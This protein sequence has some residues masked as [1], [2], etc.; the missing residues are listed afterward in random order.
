MNFS[1]YF[2]FLPDSFRL[3]YPSPKHH[4]PH[5]RR[6]DST[7]TILKCFTGL[8]LWLLASSVLAA[9]GYIQLV[10]GNAKV[11]ERSGTERPAQTG[12]QLYEGDSV[13]TSAGSTVRIRMND[14]ALLWV[15]PDSRLKI[16]AY[17]NAPAG[18]GTSRAVLNL[19]EGAM[20][21]VTGMIGKRNPKDFSVRTLTAT[22]G[23]RGTDFESAYIPAG[24]QAQRT[25]AAPGTYTRVY[26]GSVA[27]DS[28]SGNVTVNENEAAFA[29]V[30][31]GDKPGRLKEI[32]EFLRKLEPAAAP[33][34]ASTPAPSPA[35]Q[36]TVNLRYRSAD[37]ILP[38]LKPLLRDDTRVTG[39][40]SRLVIIAPPDKRAS[41]RSA[42]AA[43]DT[44]IRRLLI[45]VRFD[46]PGNS[47][48]EVRASSRDASADVEQRIQTQD[49]QRAY[50]YV[51]RGQIP[52]SQLVQIGPI[53]VVQN[54]QPGPSSGTLLEITPQTTENTVRI[55][56]V[57]KRD[58]VVGTGSAQSRAQGGKLTLRI[59]EWTEIGGQL[60]AI[61]G[62]REVSTSSRD[63]SGGNRV[64]MKVD[65]I[66]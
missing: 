19:V 50:F 63:A 39:E 31:P 21:T 51:Q 32:P 4:H 20:R 40:G 43:F 2:R 25:G 17:L 14:D 37:Q 33:Q 42:I 36:E 11:W 23:V 13:V 27:L 34:A 7:P 3:R 46:P 29:G 16:E 64:F 28:P 30:R 53:A 59:G 35:A 49:G 66:K 9:S 8:L 60:G 48:N 41:L 10:T 12:V 24:P 47:N 1:S 61:V 55:D 52:S 58:T 57:L 26:Q 5:Q 44:P 54:P 38:L 22:I 6:A 56:Y 15:H 45:T 62:S 18:N 65:E